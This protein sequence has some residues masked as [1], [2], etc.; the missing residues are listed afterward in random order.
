VGIRYFFVDSVTF[1]VVLKA[2]ATPNNAR[3]AKTRR[4]L[5]RKKLAQTVVRD[6]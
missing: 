1:L 4:S 6:F 3:A 5:P 2:P